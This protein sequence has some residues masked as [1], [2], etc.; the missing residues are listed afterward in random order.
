MSPEEIIVDRI[1]KTCRDGLLFDSVKAAAIIREA[2]AEKDTQLSIL[3]QRVEQ[4]EAE[5]VRTTRNWKYSQRGKVEA[6]RRQKAAE[7]EVKRLREG[8]EACN[9]DKFFVH[10]GSD[11]AYIW[12]RLSALLAQPSDGDDQPGPNSQ[13]TH[14]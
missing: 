12:E 5:I 14:K 3:T 8:I 1:C 7:A 9:P 11:L 6:L 2:M 4:A 13:P 10:S